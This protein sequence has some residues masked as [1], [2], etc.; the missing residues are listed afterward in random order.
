MKLTISI[1]MEITKEDWTLKDEK[2]MRKKV[3]VRMYPRS[4]SKDELER[5]TSRI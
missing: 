3:G 2:I 1:N 4:L 5:V